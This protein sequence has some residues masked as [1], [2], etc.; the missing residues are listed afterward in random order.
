M[1]SFKY[2]ILLLTFVSLSA[3]TYF[4]DDKEVR[5]IERL[6]PAAGHFMMDY[7]PGQNTQVEPQAIKLNL[8]SAI[9]RPMWVQNAALT[10]HHTSEQR[11]KI[12]VVIDDLGLKHFNSKRAAMLPGPLTMAYLPYADDLP[13]QTKFAKAHGHELM[14]HMPM[15]PLRDTADPGP[16]VLL[17][18]LKKAELMKRIQKNLSAF[19]GYVGIN[20]HMGSAF[21][22]DQKG[23]EILMA[24]LQKRDILYLDSRTSATSI[25]EPTA[26]RY[27]VATTGRDVFLDHVISEEFIT[28]AL[29]R[30]E[31]HALKHG[32]VIAIGHPHDL[33]LDALEK[34]LPTLE[35]KGFELVPITAIMTERDPRIQGIT[36]AAFSP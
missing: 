20:N 11:P 21:T 32:S 25:A 34:W 17:T 27:N 35:R 22:Q 23:L 15:Q 5:E 4:G 12:V 19:D 28:G 33:T 36:S 16:N 3:C 9:A 24:E 26:R 13:E 2:F 30:A 18:V 6:E 14:V 10:K 29:Q 1:Q 7:M 31:D 8:P